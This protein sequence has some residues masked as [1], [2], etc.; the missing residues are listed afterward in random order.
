MVR[1]LDP[2]PVAHTY[3]AGE[4]IPTLRV[5][6]AELAGGVANEKPGTVLRCDESGLLVATASGAI[7]I[8]ELQPSGARRMTAAEFARGRRLPPGTRLGPGPR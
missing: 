4:G 1:A 5:W 7:N 6:S 8:T 2:W 3:V